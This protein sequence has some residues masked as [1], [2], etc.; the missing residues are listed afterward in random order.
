MRIVPAAALPTALLIMILAIGPLAASAET[1]TVNTLMLKTPSEIA[2]ASAVYNAIDAMVI[3]ADSC[4][5]RT[6]ACICSFSSGVD[7]LENAYRTA[8]ARH[9][10]WGQPNTGVEYVNPGGAGSVGIVM[11]NVKRQLAMC[12][13]E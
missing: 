4:K 10:Q 3:H 5:P 8:V 6:E 11:S 9:P 7:T 13:R 12:G 2:D 1:P